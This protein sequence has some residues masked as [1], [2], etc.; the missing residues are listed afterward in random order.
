MSIRNTCLAALLA[1]AA[2]VPALAGEAGY[3]EPVPQLTWGVGQ[4]SGA[5]T[6]SLMQDCM[7]RMAGRHDH[8]AERNAHRA[9]SAGAM[10]CNG[11]AD[12]AVKRPVHD[13]AKFHKN[14]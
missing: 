9:P 12:T 1:G 2:F 6:A 3:I 8:G 11:T 14:Q 7:K 13:H 5:E 10:K 4:S